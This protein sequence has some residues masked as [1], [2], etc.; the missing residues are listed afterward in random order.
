M[1]ADAASTSL[2]VLVDDDVPRAGAIG[3][4]L[5]DAGYSVIWAATSI[6]GLI[7]IEDTQPALVVLRWR[8]PLLAGPTFRESVSRRSSSRQGTNRSWMRNG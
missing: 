7:A 4:A 6:E 2:L 5:R 1:H 8:I 3:A